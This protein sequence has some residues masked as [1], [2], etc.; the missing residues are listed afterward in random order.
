[1]KASFSKSLVVALT[2][3][4]M[5]SIA[6][7]QFNPFNK[8]TNLINSASGGVQNAS[9]AV[10]N[11]T[12]AV[13][14][15]KDA[16]Q[17]VKN[18]MPQSKQTAADNNSSSKNDTSVSDDKTQ[19]DDSQTTDQ[20]AGASD[21]DTTALQQQVDDLTKEND[22]LIDL[23]HNLSQDKETLEEAQGVSKQEALSHY[24]AMQ[25][26]LTELHQARL[27]QHLANRE[28]H[29]QAMIAAKREHE[30]VRHFNEVH[31]RVATRI[32]KKESPKKV[33]TEHHS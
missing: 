17:S 5:A 13:Q 21:A 30:P 26:R 18:V 20:Q 7:A 3:A 1:L 19:Q 24:A 29:H 11:A 4:S 12:G 33:E 10:Q 8:V 31:H 22:K 27:D 2:L 32:V 15:A 23:V 9:G 6:H 25:N 14:N 28:R 16:V